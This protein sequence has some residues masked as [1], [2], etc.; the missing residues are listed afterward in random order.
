MALQKEKI[1][2]G[3]KKGAKEFN[4][5]LAGKASAQPFDEMIAELKAE[6]EKHWGGAGRGQ[7]RK[8][9]TRYDTR[10]WVTLEEKELIQ[11]R[12]KE[13]NNIDNKIK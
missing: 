2:E 4:L 11:K 6:S 12:R 8:K 10:I 3:I 1:I 13:N 7:G 9:T 5:I